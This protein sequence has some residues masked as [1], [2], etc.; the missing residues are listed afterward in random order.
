MKRG[1]G[2]SMSDKAETTTE[3]LLLATAAAQLL[4]ELIDWW[5]KSRK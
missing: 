4:R 2:D 3:V 5:R 1:E